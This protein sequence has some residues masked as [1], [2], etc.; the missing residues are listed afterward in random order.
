MTHAARYF[1]FILI[2][3]F[4][5]LRAAGDE[6]SSLPRGYGAVQLGMSMQ[7]T[8]SAL[9]EHSEFNY[10]GQRDVSLL[11]GEN[12]AIIE[13]SQRK[14]HAR[15]YLS[16]CTFQF[17]D[18]ELRVIILRLNEE[19]LD[20]YSVFEKLQGK[21]GSPDTLDPL[22]CRWSDDEVL[23]EL[24]RPLTLKYTSSA[25]EKNTKPSDTQDSKE[26]FLDRL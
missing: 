4:P 8:K 24:E 9:K 10:T 13:T 12:R 19:K 1:C 22:G 20:Y 7:D 25:S 2:F 17:V 26:Q 21:Y 3:S 18:D 6:S 5:L 23:F 16:E 14:G 11:R 15:G